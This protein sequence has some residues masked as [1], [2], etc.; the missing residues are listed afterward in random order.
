LAQNTILDKTL[1]EDLIG[2]EENVNWIYKSPGRT[3][4]LSLTIGVAT[5]WVSTSLVVENTTLDSFRYF[6]VF[7]VLLL[8]PIL[9][10]AGLAM[11]ATTV[12]N[13]TNQLSLVTKLG[14]ITAF[15]LNL[16]ALY[17]FIRLIYRVLF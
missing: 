10:I 7:S 13:S 6:A 17:V 2:K 12:K 3:T 15:A 14:V 9:S 8:L 4:L 11:I 1:N 5:S 16:F